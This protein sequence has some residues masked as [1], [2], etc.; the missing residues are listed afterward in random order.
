[1]ANG[2]YSYSFAGGF[3]DD[4]VWIDPHRV[5]SAREVKRCAKSRIFSEQVRDAIKFFEEPACNAHTAVFPV[6]RGSISEI[7]RSLRMD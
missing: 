2:K 6:E 3:V 4:R 7:L 1:M 5:S